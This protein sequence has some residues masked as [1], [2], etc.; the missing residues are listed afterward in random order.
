LAHY[1]DII[2]KKKSP[3]EIS[4]KLDEIIICLEF[5]A[6]KD[7]FQTNYSRRLAKRLIYGHSTCIE[8]ER[9]MIGRLKE[10]C[11]YEFTSKI[12]RMYDDIILSQSQMGEYHKQEDAVSGLDVKVLGKSAWP[13]ILYN[14]APANFILP[15]ELELA[16]KSYEKYY[17]QKHKDQRRLTWLYQMS[18]VEIKTNKTPKIQLLTAT[19]YQTAILLA[20]NHRE[21]MSVKEMQDHTDLDTKEVHK[22]LRPLIDNE[23]LVLL[24]GGELT[25]F[26]TLAIN[27]NFEKKGTKVKLTPNAQKDNS[28][29]DKER[30]SVFQTVQEDRKYWLQAAIS[31]IMK[32][33]RQ[34]TYNELLIEVQKEA[35]GSFMP[36][37]PFMKATLKSLIEKNFIEPSSDSTESAPAYLYIA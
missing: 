10:V 26:T 32:R 25:E 19:T 7:I 4:D 12:K 37:T 36:N 8:S 30:A 15:K 31:R 9:M 21:H 2:L 11:L 3:E 29:T 18:V 17:E 14:K 28:M 23:L 5:V 35:N 22:Q 16:V 33:I 34:A 20:F 13:T 24:G 6:E 27:D 1:A